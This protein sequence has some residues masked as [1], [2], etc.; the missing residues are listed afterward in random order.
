L[1]LEAIKQVQADGGIAMFLDFEHALSHAYASAL[2][3]DFD[4]AK[5]L[6]YQPTTLEQ[7]FEM[8]K[9]AIVAGVDL[10]VVDSVAAMV[11]QTETEKSYDES[12]KVGVL[13]SKLSTNLPKLTSQLMTLG[14][15]NNPLGT[16][17]ILLNQERAVIQTGPAGFG[18]PKSQSAG[19]NALKFYAYLRLMVKRVGSMTKDVKDPMTKKMKKIPYGNK[20]TVKV[21]KSKVDAKQGAWADIFIRYG[22]GID[23]IQTITESGVSHGLIKRAGSKYIYKDHSAIG[24]E[25]FRNLL[26]SNPSLFNEIRDAVIDILNK[27]AIDNSTSEDE[28]DEYAEFNAISETE[29]VEEVDIPGEVEEI[30]LGSDEGND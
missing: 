10:I 6:H 30:S 26:E 18:G 4:P 1:A 17:L 2:G 11:P 29:G 12:A 23:E 19:G 22:Q 21:V 14:Q 16:A 24:V 3:V 27:Q 7:G 28:D 25:K 20:T 9:Y 5:L 13:A 15:D 8:I